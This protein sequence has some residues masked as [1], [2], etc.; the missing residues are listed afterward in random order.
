[1]KRSRIL[2][3]AKR[4]IASQKRIGLGMSDTES[5]TH[6][7]MAGGKQGKENIP[8]PSPSERVILGWWERTVAFVSNGNKFFLGL[9]ALGAALKLNT[10]YN[11]HAKIDAATWQIEESYALP[12]ILLREKSFD[13]SKIPYPILNIKPED[14]LPESSMSMIDRQERHD[15]ELLKVRLASQ[16]ILE[17]K[18]DQSN[19]YNVMAGKDLGKDQERLVFLNKDILDAENLSKKIQTENNTWVFSIISFL[20]RIS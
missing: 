19:T 2:G 11:D 15:I 8:P 18:L 6:S 4:G 9:I 20:L 16:I 13:R 3:A 7:A 5:S 17:S 1:M 12:N 14:L 10:Y